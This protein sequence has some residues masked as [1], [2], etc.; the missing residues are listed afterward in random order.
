M[1]SDTFGHFERPNF[2]NTAFV[3]GTEEKVGVGAEIGAERLPH[4]V[5]ARH[6]F[7]VVE[8]SNPR[9]LVAVAVGEQH[10]QFGGRQI[11]DL[12]DEVDVVAARVD[13]SVHEKAVW[14]DVGDV[15]N[16]LVEAAR[17]PHLLDAAARYE[18]LLDGTAVDFSSVV[19]GESGFEP[20]VVG[21]VV[22]GDIPVFVMRYPNRV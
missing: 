20:W 18:K 6:V 22:L 12:P 1:C 8:A 10:N 4:S 11:V 7:G 16:P 19:L 17:Y 2:E 13:K 3:R 14:V 9:R 15:D 21:G 5:G